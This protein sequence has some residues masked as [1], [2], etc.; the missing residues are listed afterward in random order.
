V[1]HLKIA[2]TDTSEIYFAVFG[3]RKTVHVSNT[4]FTDTAAVVLTRRDISFVERIEATQFGIPVFVIDGES[5]GLDS[6]QVHYIPLDASFD[7]IAVSKEIERAASAYEK[8]VLPP[9]FGEM[10]QYL[11]DRSL[12]MA[13][14]GHQ[15]GAFFCRTPAGRYFYDFF[16][17]NVF[18]ADMSSSDVRMGDLLIHEGVPFEAQ[19]HAAHVFNADKTYFVLNG[20]STSNEI[21]TTALL[22]P[23]D[24]VLFDRNNH[25][26]VYYGALIMA[27][28]TP[29]YLETGR[30][31][32]GFIGGIDDHCLNEEYIRSRIADVAPE[33]AQEPRPFR[34]AVIQLGTYDGTIYNARQIVQR[35][36]KLCDYILFDS[37]WVGY[38]QFIP[39]MKDCSPLLLELGA[40]DPG[41]MVT[42][43]VHKQLCGFSQGS[44]IHKKDSHLQGQ[45][46]YCPHKR[47]NN[48]FMIHAS[49]SP[50]YPLFASLDVNA[51]IHE[52]AAGKRIWQDTVQLGIEV[53]KQIFK[54]CTM[55]HPFVP[56][57]VHGKPWQDG[58]TV[59]MATD[60]A[61]F[62]FRR[63]EA[64][65][66]FEQ[67]G[68]NQYFV[69]PCK[70]LLYT[71]GIRQGS[72][73]YED[74]GIPAGIVSEF[75]RENGFMPEKSDL[76]SILY[77]LTPADSVSKM[78]TMITLLKR[79][80]RYVR[81]DMP[82]KAVLPRIVQKQ[83]PRYDGYT[84]RQL[85]QEMHDF[86][87][88]WQVNRL[89]HNLFR[90]KYLPTY[91]M[92]P[93]QANWKLVG[94]ETELL[95]LR[96]I[97]GRIAAEG[98]LPYPP[99]ILCVAPGERW[100]DTAQQY[101]LYWEE[102]INLFP[103]FEPEI[104][105]VYIEQDTDSIQKRMYV[106]VV[107]E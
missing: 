3:R 53:R 74:F 77:L 90:R 48:A 95:P 44:Q 102:E 83:R 96:D 104:H 30:N 57:V 72:W 9:F 16:G 36:G 56:P 46:R 76:Y 14:P 49:T 86:S 64:W 5:S 100:S 91:A 31:P 55:L 33:R 21:V 10:A 47:F 99:G 17:Q 32:Y 22:R 85:C 24:L 106:Q 2:Y 63:G 20:T 27:G 94:N 6:Q 35:I 8:S 29:V 13:T 70:I 79:F 87:K 7:K 60:I 25:K 68:D 34:L 98:A 54:D 81:E 103:G 1:K 62:Q 69:D 39:M 40:D 45:A 43:S 89:Q 84:I 73:E 23:H 93:Q 50:F 66:S 18:R 82:L 101:F 92:S 11:D 59:D 88:R 19:Q 107:K 4:D 15:A 12:S 42:Q 65:H 97:S 105:G 61:Y 71:D 67:Y 75:C 78:N 52:G 51:K 38:E 80:E 26:S 41:I 37:A 28:A 58:T